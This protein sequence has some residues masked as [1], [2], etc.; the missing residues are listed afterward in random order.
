MHYSVFD[1]QLKKI[2]H[3]REYKQTF[4][5]K[6]ARPAILKSP[7][8]KEKNNRLQYLCNIMYL[9]YTCK[10]LEA[11]RLRTPALNGY[12]EIKRKKTEIAQSC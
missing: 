1:A 10:E 4:L 9:R 3:K 5:C 7:I 8:L 2:S 6:Q 12:R 11:H